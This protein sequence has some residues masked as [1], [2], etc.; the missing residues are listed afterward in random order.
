MELQV[1]ESIGG[2]VALGGAFAIGWA[3]HVTLVTGRAALLDPLPLLALGAGSA[4]VAVGYRLDRRFEPSELVDV[5]EDDDEETFDEDASPLEEEWLEDRE[6]D[7]TY[8]R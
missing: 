2:T 6:R 5:D 1:P 7:D 3:L 8:E 4:L